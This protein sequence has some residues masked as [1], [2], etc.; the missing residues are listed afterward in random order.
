MINLK[1]RLRLNLQKLNRI[2]I[3][4]LKITYG[5]ESFR[6]SFSILCTAKRKFERTSGSSRF[7]PSCFFRLP[8]PDKS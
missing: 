4:F 1:T 6:V 5:T 8:V 2:L 7:Y 3:E